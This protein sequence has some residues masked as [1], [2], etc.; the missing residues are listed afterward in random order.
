M[1]NEMM[2]FQ[3]RQDFINMHKDLLAG[4]K[5]TLEHYDSIT[6]D[7]KSLDDINFT[8]MLEFVEKTDHLKISDMW[9]RISE[10]ISEIKRSG[11]WSDKKYDCI[12]WRENQLHIEPI[13][14]PSGNRY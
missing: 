4:K 6:K 3:A 10:Y 13:S 11:Q 14:S 9:E 1:N 5:L 2:L 12:V 8:L 7:L